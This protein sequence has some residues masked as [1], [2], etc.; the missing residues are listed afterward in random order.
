MPI[1]YLLASTDVGVKGGEGGKQGW[2]AAENMSRMAEGWS[3]ER[4]YSKHL[5]GCRETGTGIQT[6]TCKWMF[7]ALFNNSQRVGT[8]C[9]SANE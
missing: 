4:G 9:P 7:T 8:Q 6:K 3:V 1:S 2:K 5:E